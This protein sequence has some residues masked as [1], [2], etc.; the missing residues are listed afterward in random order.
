MRLFLGM[1]AALL[2]L[3]APA[4]ADPPGPLSEPVYG[5]SVTEEFRVDTEH[6]SIYGWVK[7][8]VVP[9]GVKVPVILTYSP[10][11]AIESPAPGVETGDTDE[12]FVPRGYA[13]AWVH[14]V[15]TANSGGCY[16]YGGPAEQETGHDV[17][18][19]LGTQDWS[20]GRVG[21][22]GVSYDG[23]TQWATAITAPPHLAA[24]IPQAA[25][26][27]WYD[28]DFQQ[29]VRLASGSGTPALFDFGF[30][31]IP[32]PQTYADPATAEALAESMRPCDEVEHNQRGYLPDPVYDE[33]W[34]ARDYL[35][36]AQN[37][38]A[39]VLVEHGWRD[40][41]VHPINATQMWAALPDTIDARLVAGQYGHADA[42][43]EN[44]PEIRHAF[45]DH[46]LLGRPSVLGST[47]RVWSEIV[48]DDRVAGSELW[49]PRGTEVRRLKLGGTPGPDTL[50][51]DGEDT[52]EWTDSD[53]NLSEDSVMGGDGDDQS[54]VFLGEPLA[55]ETRIAGTPVLDLAVTT[56]A[57]ETF[58]TP[59]LFVERPDGAREMLSRATL[60]SRNRNSE[61]KSEPLQPGETWRGRARFQPL[62]ILLEP[63]SKL[64]LAVMSMNTNEVLYPDTSRATNTLDLSETR[65]ELP[66]APLVEAPAPPPPVAAPVAAKVQPLARLLSVRRSGRVLVVKV[67]CL[68]EQ[69]CRLRS[70]GV[71]RTARPGRTAT[72]RIRRVKRV[73]VV[74][75]S[76]G[77][78]QRLTRRLR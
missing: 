56:S 24:I 46:H 53:P 47:P 74:V 59:T 27:R 34:L 19:W 43:F 40:Y 2:T 42:S 13:R 26:T 64:G 11:A 69:P 15:G 1:L 66:V 7:R 12:F 29:G 50:A 21:M 49:P 55:A 18:E 75:R 65:L 28:Y 38:K 72:L 54:I 44:A 25:I 70:A 3:A 58:V 20:N 71:R 76:G 62:D 8:P 48:E 22:I 57:A 77:Q 36:R 31:Q 30:N 51:F 9:E 33:F 68:A 41:N 63:G 67:R 78:S 52:P 14:L 73:T 61:A 23:T 4:A 32:I 45:F 6:G 10:Y 35:I 17:V 16:D 60:N 37:I 39:A 5:D